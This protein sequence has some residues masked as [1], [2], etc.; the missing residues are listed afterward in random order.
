MALF[1]FFLVFQTASLGRLY[2]LAGGEMTRAE[3][4]E[5]T[6]EVFKGTSHVAS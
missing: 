5:L 6:V 2:K 3:E 1:F 4:R